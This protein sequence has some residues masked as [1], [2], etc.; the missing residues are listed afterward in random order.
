MLSNTLSRFAVLRR[1][2]GSQVATFS[3]F[4]S[5]LT[6]FEEWLRDGGALFPNLNIAEEQE[7]SGSHLANKVGGRCVYASSPVAEDEAVLTLPDRFLITPAMGADTPLGKIAKEIGMNDLNGNLFLALY[8][9]QDRHC[10]ESFHAPYYDALPST[11][12]M[13]SFPAFW[14][15]AERETL[16]AGSP[17][18]NEI[19]EQ[20][21]GNERDYRR[22]R[23][24]DSSLVDSIAT[25]E[26]YMWAEL[27]VTSRAFL[28]EPDD[29]ISRQATNSF[30]AMVPFADM[31]NT[32]LP[33]DC[34]VSFGMEKS[35]FVMRSTAPICEGVQVR[36]SY[37]YKSNGRY[38]LHYGFSYPDNR[39]HNGLSPN[40]VSF[41]V[42]FRSPSFVT[43]D[44]NTSLKEQSALL[45]RKMK[46][47]TPSDRV[48]PVASFHIST[49]HVTPPDIPESVLGALRLS[50]ANREEL[51]AIET[52][53][54][55][56]T[57]GDLTTPDIP[58]VGARNEQAASVALIETLE[59]QLRKYPTSLEDDEMFMSKADFSSNSVDVNTRNARIHVAGEKRILLNWLDA[60]KHHSGFVNLSNMT[61]VVRPQGGRGA[62][63]STSSR[64][65]RTSTRNIT[66]GGDDAKKK[67]RRRRKRRDNFRMSKTLTA[68]VRSCEENT[69]SAK[70]EEETM[71]EAKCGKLLLK[72]G[73]SNEGVL[74]IKITGKWRGKIKVPKTATVGILKTHIAAASKI[75]SAQQLILFKGK[76]LEDDAKPISSVKMKNK[77]T[78]IVRCTKVNAVKKPTPSLALAMDL[79]ERLKGHGQ[80]GLDLTKM[81]QYIHLVSES[82]SPVKDACKLYYKSNGHIGTARDL[83]L[84]QKRKREDEARKNAGDV[85][86]NSTVVEAPKDAS[87]EATKAAETKP[88]KKKKDTYKNMIKG[89]TGARQTSDERR[90]AH[91]EYLKKNLGGGKFDKLDK[92]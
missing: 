58:R 25:A 30:H 77:A 48:A 1:G 74:E 9:L 31:L 24:A 66:S 5:E 16:L 85:M 4:S 23:D 68:T 79:Q 78:V 37:G 10:A 67:R 65:R 39:D 69:I 70:N 59:N 90:E 40:T 28:I 15:E 17:L 60:A 92:I 34:D 80:S 89:I 8:I 87:E 46:V 2:G 64:Y 11:Y 44:R 86:A 32:A 6:A 20:K 81:E 47:W 61:G 51:D 56:M 72:R 42:D 13:A 57:T 22:L 91:K 62:E 3:T 43:G 88:K 45:E 76:K 49:F 82:D 73:L 27:I 55:A 84:V 54:L 14:S 19:L 75:E 83:V 26:D 18:R 38:L 21:R 35:N 7:G 63:G 29:D 12:Q 33:H 53:V 36:D 41:D 50:V 71:A 52:R